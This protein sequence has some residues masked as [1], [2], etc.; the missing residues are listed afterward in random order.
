MTVEFFRHKPDIH[1]IPDG[2]NDPGN[3]LEKEVRLF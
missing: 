3:L 1:L 2:R